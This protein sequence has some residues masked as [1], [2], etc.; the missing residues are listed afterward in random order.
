MSITNEILRTIRSHA[1]KALKQYPFYTSKTDGS[2]TT[3]SL[4]GDTYQF[5]F[6]AERKIT[7]FNSKHHYVNSHN[8]KLCTKYKDWEGIFSFPRSIVFDCYSTFL[9][10]EGLEIRGKDSAKRIGIECRIVTSQVYH[11]DKNKMSRIFGGILWK[12]LDKDI[13]SLAIKSFG[14]STDSFD[15]ALISNNL[16]EVQDTLNKAPSILPIWRRLALIKILKA[17]FQ[18]MPSS[19]KN[20]LGLDFSFS[21]EEDLFFL[22]GKVSPDDLSDFHC[23]NFIDLVK[24]HLTKMGLTKAAWRFLL[25]LTPRIVSIILHSTGTGKCLVNV[26]NWFAEIGVVPRHSLVKPIMNVIG[27]LFF[28]EDLTAVMRAALTKASKMRSGIKTFYDGQ[29]RL[30]LDWFEQ[31]G[32]QHDVS[33]SLTMR[34]DKGF[35]RTKLIQLDSN[36]RKTNWDWFMRQ[37]RQWHDALNLLERQRAKE[38]TQNNTW[39]SLLEETFIKGFKVV[40]LLSS[41]DLIDEGKDMHHCVGSYSD[42]C[43]SG[44]SRIFS[45]RDKE[46]NKI[47]T[48]E[49]SYSVSFNGSF[50]NTW[51]V[52]QCRAVCN[53]SVSNEV[54]EVAEEV[55][56]QYNKLTRKENRIAI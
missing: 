27:H 25:K 11:A 10:K 5:F 30:V 4:F 23:P 51:S 9:K 44:K 6:D 42:N 53:G 22:L 24:S 1:F 56:K 41:Y 19:Q 50:Q 13:A 17:C 28:T 48:L 49:L 36:Q 45:I 16:E 20:K 3:L 40:P 52:N 18:K 43:I 7:W 54:K 12:Y 55:A 33:R 8:Y 38:A 29:M 47:A 21:Y 37:Q 35:A 31:S 2:L 15:Y 46:D 26:L 39:D 34:Q 32:V 14:F